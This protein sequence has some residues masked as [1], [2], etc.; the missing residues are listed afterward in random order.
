MLNT[1][2]VVKTDNFDGPLALLL[3]LIQEEQ[4]DIRELDLMKITKQ[5]LQYLAQM[6]ELNFDIAGDYLYLAATLILLKSKSC[7]TEEEQKELAESG[8]S[9]GITSSAELIRRLE[10]LQHYQEMGKKL[11][12][13]PKQGH[14]IFVKP[15]VDKKSIINSILTPIELDK[16]TESMISLIQKNKK[17][18]TVMHRDRISIKEKLVFLKDFLKP[19]PQ[20]TFEEIIN[21][22]GEKDITNIVISFISV[23]ELARLK[24]L[25]L[26][27]TD[28]YGQIYLNVI[29][30][31]ENFDVDQATGFEEENAQ[32]ES[33]N[34]D[35]ENIVPQAEE[36]NPLLTKSVEDGATLNNVEG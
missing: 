5:Y 12:A 25:E 13:L 3:H 9:L 26:F 32:K 1:S 14:E 18:F 35:L 21:A 34:F 7:I 30:S 23:L 24:K 33:N 16:L 2:I 8:D 29:E 4:M 15:K 11:W 17:K 31:L 20:I 10:E 28:I 6:K 36:I 27:Q 19:G 22:H